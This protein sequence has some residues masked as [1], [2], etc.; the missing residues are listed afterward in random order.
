MNHEKLLGFEMFFASFVL[1]WESC[2][3]VHCAFTGRNRFDFF[4]RVGRIFQ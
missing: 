3:A 4:T 1:E 2:I